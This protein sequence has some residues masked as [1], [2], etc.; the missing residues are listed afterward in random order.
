MIVSGEERK[1][2][3]I[4][5]GVLLIGAEQLASLLLMQFKEFTSDG[6]IGKF[7][8][9]SGKLLFF[10]KP[11]LPVAAIIRPANVVYAIDP[12][13][14]SAD[15]IQSVSQLRRNRIQVDPAALLKISELRNF[16][17]VQENLPAHSP[18][19]QGGRFPVVFLKSHIVRGEVQANRCQTVQI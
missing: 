12:L 6:G 18:G 4:L 16:E 3:V 7:K 15:A 17:A 8:I 9:I 1:A 19:T 2:P 11:Y 13:K 14:I 5:S 10:Q